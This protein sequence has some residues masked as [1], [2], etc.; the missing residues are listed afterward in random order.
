MHDGDKNFI[1]VVADNTTTT[2]EFLLTS[3]E[4]WSLIR[5]H[6]I[7]W[8]CRN[9]NVSEDCNGGVKTYGLQVLNYS[10]IQKFKQ[11]IQ[12]SKTLTA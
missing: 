2:C 6:L 10:E 4:Q 9:V 12:A 7:S 5:E 8:Y 1:T 3:K 11:H